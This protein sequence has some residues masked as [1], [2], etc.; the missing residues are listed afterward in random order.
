MK[1]IPRS[2]ALGTLLYCGLALGQEDMAAHSMR[3]PFGPYSM[4]RDGSGTSWQPESTPMSGWMGGAGGWSI[5][6]DGFV[7]AI[8]DRQS[9]ARGD[10]KTFASSMLMV[11][12]NRPLGAGTLGLTTMLSLDPTMGRGGYPLLFQSGESADGVT[13]LVDRQHPHDAFMELSASYSVPLSA[14]ASVYAYAGL[15][16]EPALG[17][18]AFM[19][20]YSALRNPEAPLAH[21]WLDSTHITMGVVTLG[22]STGPWKFEASRF[23]GREPDQNRWNIETRAFDSTSGRVSFNP[24]REWSLQVS[25]GDLKSPEALEP[26]LRVKRTTASAIY[27]ST[28]GG[29]AWGSTL[30]WGRNDKSGH[31]PARKLDGWLL[32]S[33]L[34]LADRHALFARA[35]R[36]SNDELFG[37]DDPLHGKVFDV[38]KLSVGYVYD[39]ATVG[40]VKLGVGGLLSA[41][42]IP[43][44]LKPVYGNRPY[45]LM[46]FLQA[47]L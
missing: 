41:F 33:A 29:R 16:G 17:P 40:D 37:D 6:A 31:G 44:D 1:P 15:P 27:Q 20:R 13:T 18:P 10:T 12:A 7:N 8:F 26:D 19:H 23:N 46:V 35:E 14:R 30:A 2:L 38:G 25:Y 36:V 47:R 4:T 11:M 43:G 39:F 24:T 45:G 9:G 3:S 5:M 42:D 22:A 21:H 32:E 28:L 34:Q